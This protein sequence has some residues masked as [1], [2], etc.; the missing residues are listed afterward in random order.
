M[1]IDTLVKLITNLLTSVTTGSKDNLKTRPSPLLDNS[2][3]LID[4][5]QYFLWDKGQ[6]FKVSAHFSTKELSCH[7]SYPE[8]V[9]QKISKD[10]IQRIE[11]VREEV[12]QPLIV[13][14]AF[15]CPAWQAHLA[16][17]G[18][19]TVVAKMSQHELGNAV[20]IL[21]KD[22]LNIRTKFQD[23]CAKQFQAIGLSDKFLHVDTRPQYIRWEY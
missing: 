16:A 7:C 14:S 13:T 15:R 4:N 9:K 3:K 11:N 6:V 10:L 5:G 22:G 17:T 20:D 19:N 8:C 2:P 1:S 18:V 12:A 21:P 23:I